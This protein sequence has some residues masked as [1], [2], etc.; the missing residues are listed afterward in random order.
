MIEPTPI[1]MS[2]LLALN[3]DGGT[4]IDFLMY[5]ISE[6]LVWAPLYILLIWSVW[7]KVGTRNLLWFILAIAL[8]IL[9]ADQTANLAKLYIPK[10]RP[11]HYEP[12]RECLHTAIYD[13]RGGL[14]GTISSHA[15][16]CAAVAILC[17]SILRKNWIWIALTA[18]VLLV[19]YSRIYLGVH[20]PYDIVLG[21][22]QGALWGWLIAWSYK[23][24]ILNRPIKKK[25]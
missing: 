14:Y 10:L 12:L 25:D 22:A 6:T 7:R 21:L 9:L 20:Y 2:I 13:Y 3:G 4:T 17:G 19:S 18:W 24:W 15:A 1:D 8:V 11:S 5:Y 23:K 16:N